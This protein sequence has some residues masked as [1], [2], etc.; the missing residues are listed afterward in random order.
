ML[1]ESNIEKK[2][3]ELQ[4]NGQLPLAVELW[5]GRRFAPTWNPRVTLRVPRTAALK[6]LVRPDLAALGEAYVE[7]DV[8]VE[9]PIDEAFRAAEKL[10]RNWG[11]TFRGRLPRLGGHSKKRDQQA[12]HYHYDVSNDFY[13]LWLD[14]RMVYSCAYFKTGGEDI[15]TAQEQKLDHLCRK[16]RLQP[17]DRF[18]DIGCGWGALIIHAAGKYGVEATGVTL[19]ESQHAEAQERIRAAGLE[20]RCRVRLQDYRDIPGEGAFDK[21]ASVGMF[22]HVGLKNL[23]VYFGAVRRLLAD[24]GIVMNH[25]ITSMDTENREVDLG[26][27]EFIEKYV[28]P[29]GELPH[30]SLVLREM[31]EAK[32]EVMDVETLRLHYARTLALWSRRLEAN[33]DAAR[34]HAG[35]K[36]ARI[37][38]LYLAG[39]AHAFERGW[40]TIHQILAAKPADPARNPLPWTRDYMYR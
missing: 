28:F 38:R 5:N 1:F 11:S 12:I 23:P 24:G 19:S 8:D 13:R 30:L 3:S 7:G 20:G 2:L 9:G 26:A 36:R 40:V 10:A 33:L 16:L 31:A 22:E 39:C 37:W 17:G 21:I 14:R 35:E 27:G 29:H 32:L 25:G 34:A 15:D 18:L 4:A 6:R